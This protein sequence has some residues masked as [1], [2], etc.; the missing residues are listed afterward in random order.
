MNILRITGCPHPTDRI[1]PLLV[2]VPEL[3]LNTR[4]NT[5]E[6]TLFL[7]VGPNGSA[8]SWMFQGPNENLN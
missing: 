3:C 8:P 1:A 6:A 5:D 7:T 4:A 2:H